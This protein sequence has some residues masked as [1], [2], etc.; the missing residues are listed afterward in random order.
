[1][2]RPGSLL[3]GDSRPTRTEYKRIFSFKS[4]VANINHYPKGSTVGY[5]RTFTL[6]RDS[7]LA[8]LPFWYS[9][10]YRRVFSNKGYVLINGHKVPVVGRF[11]MNTT[12][13]D[14][15]DFP[16]F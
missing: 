12:M 15:T 7:M 9:D 3:Y 10:G 2:V 11:S 14:V 13:V 6:E 8:N 16:D 5:D 4:R 1:M